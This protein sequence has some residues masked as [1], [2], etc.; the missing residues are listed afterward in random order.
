MFSPKV[1]ANIRKTV[2]ILEKTKLFLLSWD[3]KSN[4]IVVTK[5]NVVS[6]LTKIFLVHYVLYFF[7]TLYQLYK[8][9]YDKTTHVKIMDLFWLC[10]MAVGNILC[11]EGMLSNY[12]KNCNQVG[13]FAKLVKFD[14]MMGGK[15]YI[16][17][18]V[19]TTILNVS[20]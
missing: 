5:S 2:R 4:T 9:I 1:L 7:Y 11:G 19:S 13:F 6:R 15:K 12:L 3:D 10:L 14:K 17:I 8:A 18:K 20:V 16:S